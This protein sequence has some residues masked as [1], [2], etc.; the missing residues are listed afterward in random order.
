LEGRVV[1][2]RKFVG[3]TEVEG[4]FDGTAD[5]MG[6]GGHS[7]VVGDGIEAVNERFGKTQNDR[8]FLRFQ[9]WFSWFKV[10]IG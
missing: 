3:F 6:A 1:E 2:Q 9:G 5:V 10:G 8:T 4:A 7:Q